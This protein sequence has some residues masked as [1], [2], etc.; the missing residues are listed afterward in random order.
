MVAPSN[1]LSSVLT[2]P[3]DKIPPSTYVVAGGYKWPPTQPRGQEISWNTKEKKF[4]WTPPNH[5]QEGVDGDQ[6][7]D[8]NEHSA[9]LPEAATQGVSCCE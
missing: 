8:D 3:A 2:H 1:V 5:T 7:A 4:R 6:D 9:V